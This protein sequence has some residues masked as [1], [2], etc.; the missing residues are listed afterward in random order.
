MSAEWELRRALL[1]ALRS[2]SEI[3]ARVNGVFDERPITATAPYIELLNSISN[4]WSSKSFQGREV[5][6]TIALVS[7]AQEIAPD[8]A[9][10]DLIEQA[11]Q[12]MPT[13]IPTNTPTNTLNDE[14]RYKI[15]NHQYIR[16]RYG[17][18]A[19]NRW[20][21]LIDYRVRLQHL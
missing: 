14:P 6:L 19:D 18:D 12:N 9:S 8:V 1:D 20:T 4:D 2:N 13:N 7:A 3:M 10:V 16:S 15:I 21:I 11:L 17:H 5:R